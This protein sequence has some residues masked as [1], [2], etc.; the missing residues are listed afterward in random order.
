MGDREVESGTVTDAFS[1][2]RRPGRHEVD[3]A[4]DR[5]A[6]PRPADV[7]WPEAPSSAGLRD[8]LERI[9]RDRL[10]C[11]RQIKRKPPF[12]PRAH[13]A[14]RSTIEDPSSRLGVPF[15]ASDCR[16]GGGG[17]AFCMVA[18][19]NLTGSTGGG[20]GEHS[21]HSSHQREDPCRRGPAHR[22]GG[23]AGRD[24]ER[25][26]SARFR[27]QTEPRPGRGGAHGQSRRSA[28]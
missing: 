8:V 7:A 11:D 23:R 26:R 12:P 17:T 2:E 6:R 10:Y 1:R 18:E 28:R 16:R 24:R 9:P 3:E 21:R 22:A 19:G 15:R 14:L 27:R 4:T 5:L 20:A 25:A 13:M